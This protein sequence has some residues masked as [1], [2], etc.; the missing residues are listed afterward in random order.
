MIDEQKIR[1]EIYTAMTAGFALDSMLPDSSDQEKI[2]SLI[3]SAIIAAIKEYDRQQ[4]VYC[5]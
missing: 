4:V 1:S 2:V 5:Q 3:Q